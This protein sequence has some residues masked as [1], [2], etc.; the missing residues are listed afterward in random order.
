MEINLRV[1]RAVMSR[2]MSE[3]LDWGMARPPHEGGSPFMW[4]KNHRIESGAALPEEIEARLVEPGDMA[5]AGVDIRVLC[6]GELVSHTVLMRS[7]TTSETVT[8]RQELVTVTREVLF[9][10]CGDTSFAFIACI[11]RELHQTTL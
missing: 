3:F 10:S 5:L 4:L 11:K 7:N 6:I 8:L 9:V 1:P 2:V